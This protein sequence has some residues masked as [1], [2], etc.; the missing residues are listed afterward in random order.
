[1]PHMNTVTHL[2]KRGLWVEHEVAEGP[3]Q[4]PIELVA[5]AGV[6]GDGVGVGPDAEL[7]ALKDAL[8]FG[9]GV[10]SVAAVPVFL[11]Q[12]LLSALPR[13]ARLLKLHS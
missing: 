2:S 5:E 10:P 12:T 8:Q 11:H 7:S 9:L 4:H 1:M 3:L 13:L 6:V